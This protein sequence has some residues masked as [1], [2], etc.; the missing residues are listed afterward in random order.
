MI[1]KF[2][3]LVQNFWNYHSLF[4]RKIQH[5]GLSQSVDDSIWFFGCSNAWGCGLDYN[6]SCPYVLS[7]IL[8]NKVINF[9]RPASGPMMVEHILDSLLEKYTP[10]KI[11]VAWPNMNRWQTNE[12]G[13]P[14]PVLWGPWAADLEYSTKVDHFGTKKC[15]PESWKKYIDLLENDQIIDINKEV[16]YR[17]REKTKKHTM[18]EFSYMPTS[19]L[20]IDVPL[21]PWIDMAS[22]NLHPG[23]KTQK[24]L[25]EWLKIKL[26]KV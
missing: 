3:F 10:S 2:N 7:Q 4:E 6:E 9:A 25:A 12:K 24:Y 19:N 16:V 22:D 17:V 5:N 20:D 26:E 11:I 13:I 8:E 23:A 15:F 1:E 21:Y 18:I 14:F